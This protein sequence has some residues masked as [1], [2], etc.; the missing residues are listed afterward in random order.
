MAAAVL[1]LPG[2]EYTVP[3]ATVQLAGTY[4]LEGSALNFSGTAK[5]QATVS[6]MV[7]GWKGMLLKPADRFFKKNGAGVELP[8]RIEGTRED[9]K[10]TLDFDRLKITASAH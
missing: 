5:T 1:T 4:G 2:F 3:G 9:P 10:F 7:G 6:Q 8:I